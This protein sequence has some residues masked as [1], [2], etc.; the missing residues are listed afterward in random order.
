M[1]TLHSIGSHKSNEM[2]LQEVKKSKFVQINDKSYYF[3]DGI[4][5]LPFS[6]PILNETVQYKDKKK[7]RIENYIMFEKQNLLN[8]EK[9]A[10][11][12]NHRISLLRNIF[13][14]R[15]EYYHLN[16]QKRSAENNKQ[17]N[18][19]QTTRSFVLNDFWR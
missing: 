7:E 16:S 13:Q 5:S 1:K 19:A 18:F 15:P 3:S 4:V 11:L 6:H 17:I 14:Q 9:R 12:K 8:M 2:S 10:L